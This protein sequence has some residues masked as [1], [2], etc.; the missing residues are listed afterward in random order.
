[1]SG[2]ADNGLTFGA[3]IDI[4]ETHRRRPIRRHPTTT[5]ALPIFISG[6]FGTLTLGDTDGALDWAMTEVNVGRRIARRRR[7]R[8]CRLLGQQLP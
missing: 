6:D 5:A 8:T 1:M 2:T 4:D 3:A 7:N